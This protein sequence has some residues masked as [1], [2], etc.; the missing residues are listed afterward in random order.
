MTESHRPFGKSIVAHAA[1]SLALM[2]AVVGAVFALSGPDALADAIFQLKLSS[3]VL[4]ALFLAAGIGL[5]ALRL[6]WISHSLGYRLSLRDAVMALTVGQIAGNLFFQFF[7]QLIGRSVVL[8]GRGI[9]PAASVVL[10]GYER[11]FAL[12]VSLGLAACGAIYLFGELHLDLQKGGISFL[13]VIVGVTVAVAAGA[14]FGWG[15][16]VYRLWLGITAT[17]SARLG[18]SGL[19]SVAVQLMTLSAY[20]V[21]GRTLAPDV[22]LMPL[23]AASCVIM[24]AASV[25]IS[26]AGWGLREM[27]AVVVLQAIGFS[28]A[29]ALVTGLAIGIVSLLVLATVALVFQ[30]LV[31]PTELPQPVTAATAAPD[32]TL[33]LDWILPIAAATAVFF[34]VYIPTGNGDINLNL[35]DPIVLIGAALYLLRHVHSQGPSWRI[36][37]IGIYL[38]ATSLVIVLAFLHGLLAFGFTQWAFANRLLGWGILLCYAATGALLIERAHSEG[39]AALLK[40]FA[41][42]AVAIAGLNTL[43]LALSRLQTE[44][45]DRPDLRIA[46]FSQNPNAFAFTLLMALAIVL[47]LKQIGNRP[48]FLL[49]T[50]IMIGLWYTGSRAGIGAGV[51]MLLLSIWL[52][53]SWHR[54]LASLAVATA[55]IVAIKLMPA[56]TGA[57]FNFNFATAMPWHERSFSDREHFESVWFGLSM[58]ASHPIFGAG[59][60]AFMEER[61]RLTGTP[62]VIHS[63][64]VWLMAETGILGF[65]VFLGAA[66]R[67][68]RFEFHRRNDPVAQMVLLMFC[69]LAAMSSAHDLLYQRSFWLLLGAALVC[70]VLIAGR[71][72]PAAAPP[73]RPA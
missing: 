70:P 6:K 33:A 1:V 66:F 27:S 72:E 58:F 13:Q 30:F 42:T 46:G 57:L 5:S 23:V 63:S 50:C 56:I 41:A 47:A 16:Q 17:F 26:F 38:I 25:P 54:I 31:H 39:Y 60:G 71:A 37:K 51:A 64:P 22:G 20:V 21:A 9:P 44:D 12:L 73:T 65:L 10:F 45:I 18:W 62:L 48:R 35:A 67:I 4:I 36:P 14:T 69:G 34:Q 40:T 24:F 52:G 68:V 32:Y 2:A 59:L 11:V 3:V 7:G 19:L 43:L 8:A 28:N 61:L 29:A 53:S 15:R 49:M 55:T